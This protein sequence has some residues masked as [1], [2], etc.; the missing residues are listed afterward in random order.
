VG[1]F[2][3]FLW[4]GWIVLVYTLCVLRSALLFL[5]KLLLLFFLISKA[6]MVHNRTFITYKKKV[7]FPYP[8]DCRDVFF[9][10]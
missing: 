2:G 4:A 3:S 7:V 10:C 1:F 5:I 6:E 9:F 8:L